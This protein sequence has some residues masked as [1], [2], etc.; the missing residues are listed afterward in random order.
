M[1]KNAN[2]KINKSKLKLFLEY[3]GAKRPKFL[4][5]INPELNKSYFAACA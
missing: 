2:F 3:R 5:E 1:I 4:A